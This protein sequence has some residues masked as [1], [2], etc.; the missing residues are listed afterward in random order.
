MPAKSFLVWGAGGHGRVI[1]DLLRAAG[2]DLVGFVDADSETLAL[3]ASPA[4]Y[5]EEEFME[6]LRK[7]SCYPDGV[8]ACALGIGDNRLRQSRLQLLD[9]LDAPALVHP[10][11]YVSLTATVGRSSVVFPHAVVNPDAWIGDAVI[12]NTGAIVEHDCRL[13]SAVHVSPGAVLCGGVSVGE[14]SWVGAGATVIHGIT[15]G[16]D[17]IVGAGSTVIRQVAD[18][19]TVVGSPAKAAKV[20]R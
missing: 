17:S 16:K 3:M 1:G 4:S 15:I 19:E 9:G 18:G 8:E 13:E 10:T 2:H 6:H 12:V 5:L 14:R 11:A 7:T 20:Q